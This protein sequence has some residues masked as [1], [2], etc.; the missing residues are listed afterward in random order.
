MYFTA[1]LQASA[2]SLLLS[3]RTA[4]ESSKFV[5]D[6]S[7]PLYVANKTYMGCYNGANVRILSGA[8]LS[9]I[10][11]TPQVCADNCGELGFIYSGI[12]PGGAM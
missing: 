10:D 3:S 8:K 7:A 12:K 4:A 1:I 6:P 11:M 5:C 2:L 9:T